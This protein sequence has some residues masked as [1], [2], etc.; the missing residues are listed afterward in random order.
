VWYFIVIVAVAALALVGWNRARRRA[1]AHRQVRVNDASLRGAARKADIARRAVLSG[2]PD[3]SGD[4]QSVLTAKVAGLDGALADLEGR[5]LT[6]PG[7][8]FGRAALALSASYQ[9]LN[10]LVRLADELNRAAEWYREHLDELLAERDDPGPESE[11]APDPPASSHLTRLANKRRKLDGIRPDLVV[12]MADVD[13]RDVDDGALD[14]VERTAKELAE[15]YRKLSRA[16]RRAWER[17][18][19]V[20]AAE[21]A[22][23]GAKAL[24]ESKQIME[25]SQ[26]IWSNGK[27]AKPDEEYGPVE[28]FFHQ[29]L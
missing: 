17:M 29:W 16:C 2:A 1:A 8:G 22:E 3:R 6:Q 4:L 15:E 21:R 19:P 13:L 18:F 25:I 27:G 23:V 7:P 14:E 26:P 28:I 10:R 5:P 9:R 12:R 20:R 11:T 24:A